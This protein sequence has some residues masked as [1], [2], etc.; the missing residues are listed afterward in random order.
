MAREP[1]PG[2]RSRRDD[3]RYLFLETLVSAR[4]VL[5]ISYVGRSPADGSEMAPS[6]VVSE[7]QDE[8]RR[9]FGIEKGFPL[10]HALHA[11]S[12]RYFDGSDPRLFSYSREALA[13]ARAAAREA[14]APPTP[15]IGSGLPPVEPD[16]AGVRLEDL[17]DFYRN[18]SRFLLRR[19]LEMTLR[20]RSVEIESREPFAVGGLERYLMQNDLLRRRIAGG[21]LEQA[22]GV[23][24]AGGSLP[25]GPAGRLDLADI[26]AEVESFFAA[27]QAELRPG[28]RE[29][30]E[31]EADAGGSRIAGSVEVWDGR[32][33]HYRFATAKAADRLSLWIRHLAA[34]KAGVVSQAS[35]LLASDGAMTLSIPPDLAALDDLVALYLQGL[36]LPLPF[37]PETSLAYAQALSDGADDREAM[38]KARQ[39]WQPTEWDG[40]RAEAEDPWTRQLFAGADPLAMGFRQLARRVYEPMIA[41]EAWE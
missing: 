9:R 26:E 36:S 17:E 15:F 18:P 25:H 21:D 6:V 30:V 4:D 11:W 8:L 37:F 12:P 38:K 7:L 24:R 3:D 19:R 2:D 5:C 31:I 35:R 1:R 41:C 29:T 33:L 10:E 23:M 27:H 32:L 40:A 16:P 28:S 14:P 39:A 34:L 20:D 13:A 22:R